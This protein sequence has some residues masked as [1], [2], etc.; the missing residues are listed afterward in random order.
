[1]LLPAESTT[2]TNQ[3]NSSSATPGPIPIDIN[4]SHLYGN[5][6]VT[7]STPSTLSATNKTPVSSSGAHVSNPIASTSGQV[8][9]GGSGS[10]FNIS[11]PSAANSPMPAISSVHVQLRTTPTVSA[12]CIRSNSV[13]HGNPFM[14]KFKINLIKICQSCRNGYE[15]L[16]DTM[17]LV[18][19]RAERRMIS[20]VVTGVQ[21][22][23]RESNSHYHCCLSCLQMADPSFQGMNLVIPDEIRS[24]LNQ[25]QKLYL[26]T[27]LQVPLT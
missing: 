27:C 16:N 22:L 20:N 26:L 3:P 9:V 23:G 6:H 12:S 7:A 17:G 21:F 24:K 18:V 19:A 2:S 25:Y 13:P 15:G 14:L 8:L 4:Q 1:M 10:V 11:S 5:Y